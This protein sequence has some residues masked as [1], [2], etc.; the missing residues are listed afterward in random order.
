MSRRFTDNPY[1]EDVHLAAG[2]YDGLK[3]KAYFEGAQAQQELSDRE[4]QEK[5]LEAKNELTF[6]LGEVAREACQERME[7]IIK[8]VE[9]LF[10][11]ID[12]RDGLEDGLWAIQ[13]DKWEG[14]KRVKGMKE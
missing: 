9:T 4:C 6:K 11:N 2:V 14:F 10:I 8:E 7:R 3:R 13:K 12:T 5:I 1:S